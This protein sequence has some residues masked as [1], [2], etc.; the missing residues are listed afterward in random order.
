[1]FRSYLNLI[2]S[3]C[4]AVEENANVPETIS[5]IPG[6]RIID[7][8]GRFVIPGGIDPH[9]HMQ[10]PFMGEVAADDFHQGTLAALSGGTTM[11]RKLISKEGKNKFIRTK[12]L[13]NVPKDM[14][15]EC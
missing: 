15:L 4:R 7:A 5:S 1:M 8:T 10:L 12:D 3:Y 2:L 6:F 11:V 14:D 9:T 13:N